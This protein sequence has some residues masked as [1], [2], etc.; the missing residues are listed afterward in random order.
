[1]RRGA[2]AWLGRGRLAGSA[3]EGEGPGPA[4]RRP[5]PL[6]LRRALPPEP[7][8]QKARGQT[9]EPWG[10][11]SLRQVGTE[12]PEP[13]RSGADGQGQ[14]GQPSVQ[15]EQSVPSCSPACPG[16]EKGWRRRTGL[17]CRPREARAG[18]HTCPEI[19]SGRYARSLGRPPEHCQRRGRVGAQRGPTAGGRH[20]QQG[21]AGR[22]L[23][24]RKS[25][26]SSH[27][28]RGPGSEPLGRGAV[29]AMGS[30]L[31]TG[32]E[33]RTGT[34]RDTHVDTAEGGSPGARVTG[35]LEACVPPAPSRDPFGRRA[36]VPAPWH[37]PETHETAEPSAGAGTVGTP[38]SRVGAVA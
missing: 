21:S 29:E 19:P 12:A 36:V 4:L 17:P 16:A 35:P 10:A 18:L 23:E 38:K 3:A 22:H 6:E 14:A 1:M 9:Q 20:T 24:T 31:G 34:D 8:A 15:R 37:H 27:R 11:W 25:W 28:T 2:A 5:V 26:W 13:G 7:E 33:L 32:R 30:I